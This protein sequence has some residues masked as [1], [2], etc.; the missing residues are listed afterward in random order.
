LSNQFQ[1]NS[2]FHICSNGVCFAIKPQEN[3]Q[4]LSRAKFNSTNLR[5]KQTSRKYL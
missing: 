2:G 3:G 1:I 5:M 4:I